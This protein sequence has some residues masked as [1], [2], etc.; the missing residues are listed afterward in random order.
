MKNLSK[1][2]FT[3][4]FILASSTFASVQAG[5]VKSAGQA[6]SICKA[7]AKSTHPD[8]TKSKAT[9]IKQTRGKF[10]IKLKVTTETES[11]KTVCE[12]DKDGTVTY[13]N[14]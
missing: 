11:I 2:V 8:Y 3:T 14:S 4:G 12:V 13:T 9:K 7:Q 1:L 5:E 6:T 10:K